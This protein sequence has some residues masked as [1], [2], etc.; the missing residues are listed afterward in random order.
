MEGSAFEAARE[1]DIGFGLEHVLRGLD[2]TEDPLEVAGVAGPDLDEVIGL[3][4][5]VMA[6]LDLGDA[7]ERVGEVVGR[8]AR[9]LGDP[10]EGEDV[11][12]TAAGST[13]AA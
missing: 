12:P 3:T 7:R 4:G 10:A 8:G 5:D 1:D 11:N 9:R 6:L 2:E 13:T